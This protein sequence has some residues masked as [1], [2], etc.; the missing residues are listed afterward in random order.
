M[1]TPTSKGAD[2]EAGFL[3][4]ARVSQEWP[5]VSR[6]VELVLRLHQECSGVGKLV[7]ELHYV[8]QEGK[9]REFRDGG[10]SVWA[11]PYEFR[12]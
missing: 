4:K 8:S 3:K 2:V 11:S 9:Q 5:W 6:G 12:W 1:G 7:M 10:A